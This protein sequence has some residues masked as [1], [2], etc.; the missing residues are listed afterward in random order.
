[1]SNNVTNIF[2]ILGMLKKQ[3]N[4]YG[5]IGIIIIGGRVLERTPAFSTKDLEEIDSWRAFDI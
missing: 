1:M 3:V 4:N 2:L 5:Q